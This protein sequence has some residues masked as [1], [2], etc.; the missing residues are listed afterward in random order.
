MKE[1]ALTQVHISL[2]AKMAEFAGYNMPIS[3]SSIIE[4]HMSVREASGLFD[5]SHM[6]EFIVKGKQAL[7]LVQSVSSNDASLLEIGHAQY[8]CLPNDEGGIVDDLLI[9]RLDEDNCSEGEKAFMLVVNASNIAKDWKWIS[10]HNIFDT[11]LIDISDKTALLALQ[12]PMAIKILQSLTSLDLESIPYYH[13]KKGTVAGIENV[14]VSATGYTGSGGFEL[15]FDNAHAVQMWEALMK[16][17][18]ECKLLP[19]GL[20][21]RDTLRL[22]KGYAL[23]GNDINDQISPIEAGLAWITKLKKEANFPSKDIFIGQK[24]NGV[25]RKLVGFILEERRVPRHDYLIED[26]DGKA[27]GIVTS[28]TQSPCLDKPIGMGY[29]D[30]PFSE[31]DS[32]IYINFGKKSMAARVAKIPFVE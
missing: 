2:G 27:I 26:Q 13:F 3:Y 15:Y 24:K 29:V 8:A 31:I 21:A 6:G 14:L 4:E 32:T 12:G 28:G 10:D 30:L 23:Y 16:A 17:G 22:E 1:T 18:I 25:S 11:R 20:G 9:Y 7:D 5:V 19:C